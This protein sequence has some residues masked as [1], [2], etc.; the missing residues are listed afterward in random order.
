MTSLKK[1]ETALLVVDVQTGLVESHP[2]H[3]KLF[4]ENLK[5]TITY[6]RNNGIE[7][8]YVRHD[9]GAGSELERNSAA[10]QIYKEIVPQNN[11]KIFDKTV[12]SS[13]HSTGLKEYLDEKHIENLILMGMQTE[14]CI[15]TTCKVA[16]EYGYRVYVPENTVATFDHPDITAET[17][18]HFYLYTIWNNR[19]AKVISM[20]ELEHINLL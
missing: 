5:R 4:I 6:C 18:N 3:E 17:L 20:D 7:V 8:I 2:Y 16:F 12:C 11:E 13:F 9:D 15:D 19:F 1:S 10:W 14:Y